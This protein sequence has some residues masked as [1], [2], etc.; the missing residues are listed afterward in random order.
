M[1][2]F[3]IALWLTFFVWVS[4]PLSYRIWNISIRMRMTKYPKVLLLFSNSQH[5]LLHVFNIF[6]SIFFWYF[7]IKCISTEYSF[8]A[9]NLY[10]EP[11]GR[12]H[13]YLELDIILTK[14]SPN[15]V[16]FFRTRQCTVYVRKSFRAEKKVENWKTGL[17]FW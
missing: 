8:K 13:L 12:G 7:I 6:T 15:Y 1:S 4:H 11:R 2:W 14:N 3:L 16:L 5:F 17:C 9:L 10:L